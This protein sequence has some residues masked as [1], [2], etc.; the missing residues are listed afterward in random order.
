MIDKTFHI[1]LLFNANKAY[2]RQI[3]EG[4]GKYLQTSR[5]LW[6]VF[7]A[8]DFCSHIDGIGCWN[9][10]G[11][12][13]DCDVLAVEQKLDK[14]TI[15]VVGIGGS[16]SSK[17]A[18][19]NL[20]YVATDNYSLV[21]VALEHLINKGMENFALYSFPSNPDKR[22]ATEREKAFTMILQNRNRKGLIYQGHDIHID[23]WQEA[24][25]RLTEWVM[26]LPEGTGIVAVTDSRA[27]HLLQICE[28]ADIPVPEKIAIIGIDNEELTQYL[29]GISLSS[30]V[31][32]AMKM[33]SCAA[34]ILHKLLKGESLPLQ[35]IV[36]PPL[37]LVERRSTNYRSV[38]DPY[39][40]R[41]MNYIRNNACRGIKAEQ[42]IHFTGI[43]RTSLEIRFKAHLGSTIHTF[44]HNEKIEHARHLL[45]TTSLSMKEIALTAGYPSV[46]YFY[47]VFRKTYNFTPKEYRKR[48]H[49]QNRSA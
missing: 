25:N 30:V 31:H 3:I 14:L 46:Q 38:T 12:I 32:G 45:M 48:Y 41:A 39:V 10:D 7:I 5:A 26:S 49:E 16:Y 24:Q 4:V 19:P 18:Y 6:D 28:N 44:I 36:V 37:K 15:P 34:G 27:R 22:W 43:S 9:V 2:D 35:R 1:A 42:V 17:K 11:I 13:A 29:S 20:H 33:G 21:E 23:N 47:L 8:D 40:T